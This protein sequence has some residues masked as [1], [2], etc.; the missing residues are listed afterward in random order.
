MPGR[1]ASTEPT[2]VI[3][4]EELL[5]EAYNIF[6]GVKTPKDLN[7]YAILNA[8]DGK[9]PDWLSK[10]DRQKV[11]EICRYYVEC[12][13]HAYFIGTLKM[14]DEMPKDYRKH[15][16]IFLARSVAEKRELSWKARARDVKNGV[17]RTWTV[18]SMS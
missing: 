12:A 16:E 9:H 17:G 2:Y 3:T 4:L 11:F 1:T 15:L 14:F 5:E 7:E 8:L 6:A 10:E 13:S 18:R